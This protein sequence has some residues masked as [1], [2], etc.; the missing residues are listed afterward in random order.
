MATILKDH[1][2]EQTKFDEDG[3]Q[4]VLDASSLDD[5]MACPKY[6][7]Y[8]KVM[9]LKPKH[10]K[11][12]TQWGNI[13]HK[14]LERYDECILEGMDWDDAV[15]EAVK[16]TLVE[17][18]DHD[19]TK[20]NARTTE[21]AVRAIVWYADR[22]KDDT[23][24]TA[25]LHDGAPATEIRFEVP[26]PDTNYRF[27][28]RIDRIVWADDELFLLDRKTTKQSLSGYYFK[29][30]ELSLQVQAYI[31]ASKRFLDLPVAGLL[32]DAIQTGVNFTRFN[33]SPFFISD[34]RLDEFEE[35]LRHHID[36][37]EWYHDKNYWPRNFT[38][39]GRYGGCQFAPICSMAPHRRQIWLKEYFTEGERR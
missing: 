17:C 35:L 38:S 16:A 32:I 18:K 3:K 21:T 34:G 12:S 13:V 10:N 19:D 9:A 6:Y 8:K 30:Y 31:W 4:R 39:C 15:R 11:A 24:V 37:L 7:H 5:L 28:G 36:M 14:G 22:Y 23:L 33:R 26:I 25:E 27:S 1:F 20:D 2:E 29:D